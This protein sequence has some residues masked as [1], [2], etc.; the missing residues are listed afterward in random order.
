M[1]K[2]FKKKIKT[3]NNVSQL[4]F[5]FIILQQTSIPYVLKFCKAT[6]TIILHLSTS[7]LSSKKAMK[8]KR[9]VILRRKINLPAEEEYTSKTATILL[10]Y[11]GR[12]GKLPRN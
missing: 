11:T 10:H 8:S 4:S 1:R 2:V 12:Y 6:E 9:N 3:K 7:L 5:S